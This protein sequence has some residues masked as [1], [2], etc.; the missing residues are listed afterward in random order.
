LAT[1][2]GVPVDTAA[3][4][5]YFAPPWPDLQVAADAGAFGQRAKPMNNAA[6]KRLTVV[7]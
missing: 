3:A 2:S 5:H 1:T 7:V 4:V 6:S